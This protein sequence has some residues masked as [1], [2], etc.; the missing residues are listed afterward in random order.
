M[1]LG[2]GEGDVLPVR[3]GKDQGMF[4]VSSVMPADIQQGVDLPL[5]LQSET[6]Y[7]AQ[8]IR[9]VAVIEGQA[10]ALIV[11]EESNPAGWTQHGQDHPG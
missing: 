2:L 11:Q 6:V 10:S 4:V 9:T 7:E 5:D 1:F 3:M 8:L